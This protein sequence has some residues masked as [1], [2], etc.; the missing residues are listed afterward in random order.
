MSA[1]RSVVAVIGSA[2]AN[3][4][5]DLV[6]DAEAIGR[7]VV[8]RGWVLVTGGLT[9]VMEAASR[10]G[11]SSEKC[12][13]GS[14]IGLL[15]GYDR[16]AANAHVQIALPT[17]MQLARNVL[18][19]AAA[20]VVVALHGGSGTLSEI[21]LAWQLGKPVVALTEHGGWASVLAGQSLDDR[22]DGNILPA[23]SVEEALELA[24]SSIGLGGQEPGEVGSGWRGK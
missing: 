15:P 5:D 21:A 3:L 9:G 24:T 22:H 1:R 6:N 14:V 12:A 17:G 18:V 20:D 23:G 4:P 11:R 13:V 16:D 7:G 10:G 8:D 19:V 2:G